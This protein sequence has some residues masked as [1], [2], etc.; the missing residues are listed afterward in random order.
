MNNGCPSFLSVLRIATNICEGCGLMDGVK[1]GL[2]A[3]FPFINCL[4]GTCELEKP[5]AIPG[6]GHGGQNAEIFFLA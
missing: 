1:E 4:G 3:L 2:E 6:F 5:R